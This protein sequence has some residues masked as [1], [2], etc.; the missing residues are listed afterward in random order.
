[1][2]VLN[3][4]ILREINTDLYLIEEDSTTNIFLCGSSIN[5]SDSIRYKLNEKLKNEL[6]F[7][8]IFPEWVF[9]DLL[10]SKEN[11]LLTLE[12]YLANIVDLIVIPLESIGTFAELGSFASNPF[13]CQKLFILNDKIYEH[14]KSFITQG[15]VALV[16]KIKPKNVLYFEKDKIDSALDELV[17][18][19]RYH[20][21]VGHKTKDLNNIFNLSRFLLH[22]IAIFQPITKAEIE[23][24]LLIFQPKLNRSLILPGLKIL[25]KKECLLK[26][27]I[28][29]KEVHLLSQNGFKIFQQSVIGKRKKIV[30]FSKIRSVILNERFRTNKRFQFGGEVLGLLEQQQNS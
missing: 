3:E 15:P 8:I 4:D 5:K 16:K 30:K 9:A 2:K 19:I 20:K 26:K 6:Q 29:G 7:N 22:L 18:K 11:D 23:E 27:E 1:M 13:L 17:N 21:R 12:K 28:D 10:V 25:F 14:D 24:K